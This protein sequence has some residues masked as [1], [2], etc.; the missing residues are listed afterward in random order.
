MGTQGRGV[1]H[2]VG[3]TAG[4]IQ[5][6]VHRHHWDGRFRGYALDGTVHVA[7]EH[8]IAEHQYPGFAEPLEHGQHGIMIHRRVNPQTKPR[9]CSSALHS[10]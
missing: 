2:N 1:T 3:G 5:L 7:V 8:D 4:H 6:S 10:M 9:R